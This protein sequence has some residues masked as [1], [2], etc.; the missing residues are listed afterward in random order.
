LGKYIQGGGGGQAFFAT[1][2]GKN[3]DGIKEALAAAEDIC[4]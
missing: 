2:G 4:I 3:T 1:A